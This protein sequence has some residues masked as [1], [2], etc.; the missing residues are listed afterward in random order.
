M[1]ATTA[2]LVAL[3]A[4]PL[5]A[6][7]AHLRAGL[8]LPRLFIV[9]NVDVGR[10]EKASELERVWA[11]RLGPHDRYVNVCGYKDS[12]CREAFAD[13]LRSAPQGTNALR[14][15]V[16][17]PRAYAEYFPG[18][19]CS[20]LPQV[21]QDPNAAAA[22]KFVA[23]LVEQVRALKAEGRDMPQWWLLKDDD[24]YVHIPNLM[25]A[26][27]ESGVDPGSPVALCH[28]EQGSVCVGGGG[29]L[30]SGP[31]AE[32]LA[33][34]HGEAWIGAQ[35]EGIERDRGTGADIYYD[36][37]LSNFVHRVVKESRIVDLPSMQGLKLDNQ[38]CTHLMHAC[39]HGFRL[40][41]CLC[42]RS[43]TPGTWHTSFKLS[44][45]IPFEKL[46]EYA[47]DS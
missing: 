41:H 34:K 45:R 16:E 2:G 35:A 33:L 20:G 18:K 39:E 5:A 23:G 3:L 8:E 31:L 1:R 28:C 12:G 37:V 21:C 32:L 29:V 24:T 19:R 17:L 13:R 46:L 27:R 26:V 10:A 43:Q 22:M 4:P 30:L 42:A 11:R 14:N 44:G 6:S 25:S 47:D 38:P 9:T 7:R 15:L 40:K 36:K